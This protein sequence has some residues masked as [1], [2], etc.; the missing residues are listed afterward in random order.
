MGINWG[1]FSGYRW[2]RSLDEDPRITGA[3]VEVGRGGEVRV[4][5]GGKR[6]R[7]EEM[8]EIVHEYPVP[9]V[10]GEVCGVSEEE[11]HD[12]LLSLATLWNTL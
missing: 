2:L 4:V 12:Q 6:W 7:V 1:T 11:K 3:R 10:L 9:R 8:R 5:W